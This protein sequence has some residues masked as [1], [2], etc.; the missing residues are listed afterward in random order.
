MTG[1]C[2]NLFT[3]AD[4]LYHPEVGLSQRLCVF[5][6]EFKRNIVFERERER[7]RRRVM[8]VTKCDREVSIRAQ[9]SAHA[10]ASDQKNI[11]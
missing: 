1:S 10:G 8:G 4:V 3:A 11:V 9:Y 5:E 6:A 2:S 7:G